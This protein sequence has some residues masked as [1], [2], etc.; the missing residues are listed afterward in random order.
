MCA[1]KR[2]PTQRLGLICPLQFASLLS[3]L[4]SSLHPSSY[5]HSGLLGLLFLV[6]SVPGDL[7]LQVV[8]VVGGGGVVSCSPL[9]PLGNDGADLVVPPPTSLPAAGRRRAPHTGARGVHVFQWL[10]GQRAH[11]PGCDPNTMKIY[12]FYLCKAVSNRNYMN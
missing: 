9:R 5:Q 3:S 8:V 4:L 10:A 12:L 11:S 2:T 7:T 1:H 6:G